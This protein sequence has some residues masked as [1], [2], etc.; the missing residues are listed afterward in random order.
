M[1][2]RSQLKLL[3][4]LSAT[5][6][7]VVSASH[8]SDHVSHSPQALV[9]LG[10]SM[11]VPFRLDPLL[12]AGRVADHP[13][14]EGRRDGMDGDVAVKCSW[15]SRRLNSTQPNLAAYLGSR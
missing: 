7:Y 6:D 2:A 5:V 12:M 8:G 11:V 13:E 3:Y 14:K 4:L 15:K 9:G 1:A 10:P